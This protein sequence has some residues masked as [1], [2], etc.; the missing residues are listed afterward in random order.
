MKKSLLYFVLLISA[1]SCTNYYTFLLQEDT[2]L[3]ASNDSIISVTIITKDSEVFLSSKADKKNFR[4]LKWGNY[5]R[6]AIKPIY[7]SYIGYSK[8]SS[9]YLHGQDHLPAIAR[10]RGQEPPYR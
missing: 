2:P 8:K 9:Y 4:K 10:S 1:V 5:Y 3:Y 6:W 7:T